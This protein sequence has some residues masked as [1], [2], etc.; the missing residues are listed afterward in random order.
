MIAWLTVEATVLRQ[1]LKLSAGHCDARGR[2]GAAW[3]GVWM[4]HRVLEEKA[5]A[6]MGVSARSRNPRVNVTLKIVMITICKP[7]TT[8]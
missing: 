5:R 1:G 6:N 3:A 8:N 7:N 2:E 4:E